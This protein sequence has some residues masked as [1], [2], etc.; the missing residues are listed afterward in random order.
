MIPARPS[1]WFKRWFGAQVEKRMRRCFAAVRVR[2]LERFLQHTSRGPV[3]VVSN[4]TSWWDAMFCIL[5]ST[6]LARLNGYAM[7]DA[8]NLRRLPFLG[9]AGGFGI[10]R[11]DPRS[12]NKALAYARSRLRAPGDVVWIFPQ[13]R[14]RP[15]TERPLRFFDGAAR[16]AYG[17]TSVTVIPVGIRYELGAH[18]LPT[19]L[20]S[21]GEPIDGNTAATQALAVEHE[22]D[23]IEHALCS[24][25]LRSFTPVLTSRPSH[26][27]R[28]LQSVL[29]LLTKYQEVTP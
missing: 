15:V 5:L 28:L 16:V 20:V 24:G 18:P 9:R 10:Q 2:G 12:V 17:L 6:R 3:L 4:H 22:L 29:R 13:G 21:L 23:C 14:E 8:S 1:P 26:F 27:S 19:L 7:M 11:G 25:A